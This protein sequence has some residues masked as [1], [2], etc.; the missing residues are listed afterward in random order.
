MDILAA[1]GPEAF[2]LVL[3]DIQMPVMDGLTA[4][5]RIRDLPGFAEL[6]IV[7]MTAH[8]MVHER[9]GHLADGMNDHIGKPFSLPNFL[10]L[11]ARWLAPH[12][13]P[14]AERLATAA[15]STIGD[16]G[17]GGL[18][19]IAGLDSE[20]ALERFAGNS[21]RYR[22]WLGEFV[23][24]SAGFAAAIDALLASGAREAARQATH[25]FKGRVGMLGMSELQRQ[26][27]LLE[28]AIKAGK[29]SGRLRQRL[30]ASIEAMGASVRAAIAL[31]QR[32]PLGAV[33]RPDGPRPP[34][35]DAL[36]ILFAA[37]DGGSAAA[38]EA[39]LAELYDTPWSAL[40]QAALLAVRRFDFEA[41][42]RLFAYDRT[43]NY[44]PGTP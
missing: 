35:I 3:M 9:K 18:S 41:A 30:A 7:A 27:A 31:P 14:P 10:A 4:V 16:A 11:L 21:A 29:P 13:D 15:E 42:C 28:K 1:S 33:T 6:P 8:T 23:G 25:A 20:A 43:T 44:P 36:L 5:R 38:I 26:A 40:L 12:I 2:D 19:A 32:P 34:S 39:A 22:H 17:E 37:A 24:E